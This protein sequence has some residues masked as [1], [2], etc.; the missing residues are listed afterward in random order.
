MFL[1]IFFENLPSPKKAY[2]LL[3]GLIINLHALRTKP[4]ERAMHVDANTA[5]PLSIICCI[6]HLFFYRND[7]DAMSNS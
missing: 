7:S 6:R 3:K 5:N 2:I 4:K 1:Y